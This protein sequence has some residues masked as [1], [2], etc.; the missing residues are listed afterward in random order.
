M[1]RLTLLTVFPP[2]AAAA[3]SAAILVLFSGCYVLQQGTTMLGYLYSAVPLEELAEREGSTEN[4]RENGQENGRES[5]RRFVERI[6]DIRRFASQ[7]LG[8]AS[9]SNYTKYV[10]LDRDYLAA[11]VSACAKDSFTPYEWWFPVTGS[12][13]YKGFFNEEDA[14]EE[15]AS[16]KEKDLDVWIRRVDAFSTLG[17]FSDPLY[18]YMKNYPVWRL[19][20]LIIHEQLH[21][22]VYI[23][24]NS[25]FN[26][27]LAEFVGT[28]G[29]ALYMI[30]AFGEDSE[31][32]TAMKNREADA[33][34]YISFIKGLIAEL[35]NL[36]SGPN[37]REEKLRQKEL[38]IQA[39]QK[40]FTENYSLLFRGEGYRGF[41]K[42]SINNAY[43]GNFRLYY[44]HGDYLKNL[45]TRSG[46][47]LQK[48]IEAAKTL[49]DSDSTD[50]PGLQLEKA[51]GLLPP[52]PNPAKTE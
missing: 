9:N 8:L 22:T 50:E 32:Y 37:T 26:E 17:W 45:Y 46:S 24:G 40:R 5:E 1:K 30:Q 43:L 39:A 11:V 31:E 52:A 49:G 42:L 25:Q 44:A 3:V 21:A 41:S 29:S 10:E 6:H 35:E 47:D 14:R 38:I 27:E 19:A 28:E 36:Y 34:A 12:V 48:F 7:T 2:L 33:A 16:L 13:P 51:L 15:A 4:G 20:N 23:Q 18:S